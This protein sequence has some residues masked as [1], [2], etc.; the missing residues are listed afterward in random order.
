MNV[1]KIPRSLRWRRKRS[2]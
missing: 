1:K 2:G